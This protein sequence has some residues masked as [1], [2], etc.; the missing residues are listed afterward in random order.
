MRFFGRFRASWFLGLLLLAAPLAAARAESDVAALEQEVAHLLSEYI[1]IDTTNPP[2]NELPAANFLAARF[3]REGMEAEVLESDP[4]RASVIARW[5]G[6]GRRRPV[7]LVSHIDVVPADASSWRRPPFEGVVENGVVHGRGAIDAKG[8][9]V[10][11]ALTLFELER[12]GIVLSRDVIFVATADEEAGGG[13]GLGW[14]VRH[15]AD[16]LREAEFA[17][18]EGSHIQPEPAGQKAFQIAVSE[19]TPCWLRLTA[20]GRPGHGSM[21]PSG[22]AVTRIVNALARLQTTA[23][24]PR[25]TEEVQ[26]F[27]AA[28]APMQEGPDRQRFADLRR[29]LQEAR[30]RD[31]FLLDPRQASLV[32]DTITPTILAAGSKT[33][34][35]PGKASAELDCRL[36]PDT[37]REEF[38]ASVRERLDDPLVQVEVLLHFPP[39]SSPTDTALYRA[40]AAQAE[41]EGAV[42]VPAV[43]PGFTDSHYLR[44]RGIAVYGFAPLELNHAETLGIHG[45]DERVRARALAEG[46]RRLVRILRRLDDD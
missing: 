21:P 38:V 24:P 10:V 42:A 23:P 26:S 7:L 37:S 30:F 22:T 27:F 31:T 13:A 12:Q 32:Q 43:L 4:G 19:K 11:H 8:L 6:T 3:W 29:S 14:L 44:E 41:A 16:R 40:M 2:G 9:G 1:R 36:L 45:N 33:N 34:V 20:T 15:H 17:L 5:P 46:V 18:N 28:L 35:I 39:T 25:V